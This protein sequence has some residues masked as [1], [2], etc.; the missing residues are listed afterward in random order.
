MIINSSSRLV[1]IIICCCF[2]LT[3]GC[4]TDND[5]PSITKPKLQAIEEEIIRVEIDFVAEAEKISQTLSA[6]AAAHSSKD[7]D[8]AMKYW[9]RLEKPDV[10]MAQHGWGALMSIEKWSGIKESFEQTQKKI[11]RNPIP[12]LAEKIGIDSRAKNATVRGKMVQNWGGATSYLATLR[13][14]KD[15][16]WKIRA[17]DFYQGKE[18]HKLIKEIK[19][20]IR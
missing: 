15:G 12:G 5:K 13:K 2:L 1:T 17:I 20:P 11:G 9:L 19:T 18:D 7:V 8:E 6:H 3:I 14:D 16:E 4:G 10:F